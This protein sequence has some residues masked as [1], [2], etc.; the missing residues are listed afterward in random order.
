MGIA[1][2][3]NDECVVEWEYSADVNMGTIYLPV[4]KDYDFTIEF[5]HEKLLSVLGVDINVDG[6]LGNIEVFN[7]TK[8]FPEVADRILKTKSL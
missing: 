3:A 7:L 8:M 6:S 1:V 4:P 5:D 2:V